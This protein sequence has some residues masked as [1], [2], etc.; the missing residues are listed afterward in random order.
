MK[1]ILGS[2][3]S[4]LLK[5]GYSL[6]GI[7]KDQMKIGYVITASKGYLNSN[8]IK[9]FEKQIKENGYSFEEF[10]IEDKTQEEFREFF[11]DKNVIHLE[12]GNT[13]YLLKAIRRT[14]FDSVLLELLNEG[15]VYVGTSA[16]SSV[17]GPTIGFSSHVPTNTSDEDLKGLGWVPFLIKSHYKNDQAEEYRKTMQTIKYPVRVL[18]DGQGILAEDGRYTFVGDGEEVKL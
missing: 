16:G 12:G 18:R 11:K 6:T 3:L 1:L 7:S 10:D 14:G 8:Y 13:F 9:N 4:F 5:Y 17:M 15:R 2:D